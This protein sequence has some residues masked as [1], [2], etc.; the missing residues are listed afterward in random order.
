MD[1]MAKT[2][3]TASSTPCFELC[4]AA[5]VSRRAQQPL[6]TAMVSSGKVHTCQCCSPAAQADEVAI[7]DGESYVP[8]VCRKA[9]A[10]G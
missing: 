4:T 1:F 2:Y 5:C 10:K 3:L 6:H 7:R 9:W 8:P